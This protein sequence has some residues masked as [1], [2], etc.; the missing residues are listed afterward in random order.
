MVLVLEVASVDFGG[1]NG[2]GLAKM[3]DGFCGRDDSFGGE[4][5]RVIVAVIGG[6]FC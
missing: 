5:S 4:W 6:R 1:G 3:T 2:L